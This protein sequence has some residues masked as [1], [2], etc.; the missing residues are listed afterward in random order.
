[1]LNI[2]DVADRQAVLDF[3]EVDNF[4]ELSTE[5]A[6]A[7]TNK[8]A[9]LKPEVAVKV[10][11]QF[12]ECANM[13]V[14]L[15]KSEIETAKHAMEQGDKSTQRNVDALN[16][17]IGVIEKELEDESLT[18]EQ[19]LRLNEQVIE[20]ANLLDKADERQH[21]FLKVV[22]ENAGRV[23]FGMCCVAVGVLVSGKVKIPFKKAA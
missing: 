5:K 2:Y 11:E 22:L 20:I 1:M 16:R 14:N 12:P 10:L 19:K 13:V 3:F 17:I 4:R 6:F 18:F 8:L 9:D 7:V 23:I 21:E 15:A